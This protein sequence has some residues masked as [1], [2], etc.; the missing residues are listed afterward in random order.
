MFICNLYLQRR[1]RTVLVEARLQS[2]GR[3]E[4]VVKILDNDLETLKQE[5][6]Y[7]YTLEDVVEAVRNCQDRRSSIVYLQRE[8]VICMSRFPM[9]KVFDI[10][11][12][13]LMKNFLCTSAHVLIHCQH[14]LDRI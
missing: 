8:C 14:I 3:A 6:D 11:N 12:K 9:S 13:Y 10:L 2:W 4:T 7:D 1:I 5:S